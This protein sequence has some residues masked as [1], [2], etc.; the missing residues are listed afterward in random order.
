MLISVPDRHARR[1]LLARSAFAQLRAKVTSQNIEDVAK[2][3][4]SGDEVLRVIKAA[5]AP[6]TTTTSGWASNLVETTFG[7]YLAWLAPESAAARLIDLGLRVEM[8]G[9]TFTAPGRAVG[10][11]ALPWVGESLPIPVRQN[12]F[13]SVTLTPKKLAAISV[14][15]REIA[16]M[17]GED[18]VTALLKEDGE[19][20]LDLGYFSAAAGSATVHAGLLA[21]LTAITGTA[22]GTEAAFL[23][24]I[25]ALLAV[26]APNSSGNIVF[27][28]G[29][30]AAAKI[31][32][33]FPDFK[34]PVFPS[35]AVADTRI[36][37]VDAGVLVHSFGGF[38][39]DISTEAV[40]HLEDTSPLAIG[41]AGAPNTVAAPVRSLFQTDSIGIR[42]TGR[43]AFA[44]RKTN[45]V[46][47]VDGTTW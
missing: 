33:K 14:I 35:Q 36:I 39:V 3:M 37:A 18:V 34:M 25:A 30:F 26:V 19:R 31:A 13:F 46:A 16:M 20:G 29:Q 28:T 12:S 47:F 5:T 41:T 40:V 43:V 24:D 1:S 4:R 44:A 27:V 9:G 45:A 6:A 8:Y 17:G 32:A 15:T 21:G 10:P 42:I 23:A 2:K 22:G 7:E 11:V 38:D